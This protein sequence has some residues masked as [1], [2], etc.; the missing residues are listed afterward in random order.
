MNSIPLEDVKSFGYGSEIKGTRYIT[1]KQ[2]K[3][4]WITI[5]EHVC[6]R[7]YD[8]PTAVDGM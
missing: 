2:R 1:D 7:K 4:V 8:N 5:D 6:T 3:E